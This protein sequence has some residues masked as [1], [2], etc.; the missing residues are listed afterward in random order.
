MAFFETLDIGFKEGRSFSKSFPADTLNNGTAGPLD[1]TIG[2]IIL[3][4][5]AVKDL[6]SNPPAV[7]DYDHLVGIQT[8]PGGLNKVHLL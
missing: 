4:E 1:Q 2:G 8:Q 3:N 7:I 5:T 6:V